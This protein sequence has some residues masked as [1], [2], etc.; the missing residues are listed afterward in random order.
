MALST[1]SD[2]ELHRKKRVRVEGMIPLSSFTSSILAGDAGRQFCCENI[3]DS[4]LRTDEVHSASE[5]ERAS[6]R[7]GAGVRVFDE[8]DEFEDRT[9]VE[10]NTYLPLDRF[11]HE[12][13][14]VSRRRDADAAGQIEQT[15]PARSLDVDPLALDSHHIV[16]LRHR[17]REVVHDT[18][19]CVE[20][21]MRGART[22]SKDEH[23]RCSSRVNEKACPREWV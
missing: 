15:P 20:G 14:R 7:E 8:F 9:S 6:V 12:R 10:V 21:A 19:E 11:H 13:V 3:S 1:A 16:K 23:R 5:S 17:R 2:P 18:G 4:A 22:A